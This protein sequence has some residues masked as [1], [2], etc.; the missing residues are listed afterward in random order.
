MCGLDLMLQCWHS[1]QNLT[2]CTATWHLS[3]HGWNVL[4]F[5]YFHMLCKFLNILPH[6][7]YWIY[8]LWHTYGTS[9]Y[10][11]MTVVRQVFWVGMQCF[12][13]FCPKFS[14][15]QCQFVMCGLRYSVVKLC[16]H[17]KLKIVLAGT[18]IH[19]CKMALCS[20][21]VTPFW[22]VQSSVYRT[23]VTANLI[24]PCI[25]IFQITRENKSKRIIIYEEGKGI[26]EIHDYG[27]REEK[28]SHTTITKLVFKLFLLH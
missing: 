16:C 6:F 13:G 25:T 26:S 15:H 19:I 14:L 28:K 17:S 5:I 10:K 12:E 2:H 18:N 1:Q 22:S 3:L 24:W 20:R 9:L 8:V 7:S 4:L 27:A 23:A 21:C 11:A